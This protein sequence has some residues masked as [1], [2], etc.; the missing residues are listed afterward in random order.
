VSRII[1]HDELAEVI[2][3]GFIGGPIQIFLLNQR[4]MITSNAGKGNR[5][6]HISV[7]MTS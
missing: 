3:T 5:R 7:D 2:G 6:S 4:I 1:D